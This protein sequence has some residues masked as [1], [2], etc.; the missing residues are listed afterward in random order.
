MK[1]DKTLNL[2]ITAAVVALTLENAPEQADYKAIWKEVR[3][4][5]IRDTT[6]WMSGEDISDEIVHLAAALNNHGK[7]A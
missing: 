7:L 3:R 4:V 2:L 6:A 1:E 5:I